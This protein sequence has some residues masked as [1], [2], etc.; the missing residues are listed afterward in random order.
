MWTNVEL[1]RIPRNPA[2][3]PMSRQEALERAHEA[4]RG[5][6]PI[7]AQQSRARFQLVERLLVSDVSPAELARICRE[8]LGMSGPAVERTKTKVLQVWASADAELRGVR[9]LQARKRLLRIITK[10]MKADDWRAAI[11]AETLLAKVDGLIS[12]ERVRVD[13]HG[14]MRDPVN[15]ALASVIG[16]L[17]EEER[18]R[19][20][21]DYNELEARAARAPVH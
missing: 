6:K 1:V 17:T 10:A 9:R 16:S 20:L 4:R 11:A 18:D 19:M 7:T 21:A 13:V 8:E 3:P 5:A 12:P 15:S 2:A 14:G